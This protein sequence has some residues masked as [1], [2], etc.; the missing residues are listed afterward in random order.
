MPPNTALN[1]RAH[2]QRKRSG[3]SRSYT[4][5]GV[6][7][8]A[9]FLIR[10]AIS[11]RQVKHSTPD[12]L[13]K[14]EHRSMIRQIST[15]RT[16]STFILTT[17]LVVAPP[18]FGSASIGQLFAQATTEDQGSPRELGTGWELFGNGLVIYSVVLLV[19][20]VILVAV[21]RIFG[22][23]F[24]SEEEQRV[25]DEWYGGGDDDRNVW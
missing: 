24:A 8:Y 9:H 7:E 3:W 25:R 1:F 19:I 10:A 5:Q 17:A 22:N 15:H 16:M 20:S 11:N 14:R 21:H 2:L 18:L 4:E 6:R 12:E 13:R 23:V